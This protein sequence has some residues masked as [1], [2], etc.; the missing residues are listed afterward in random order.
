M[1]TNRRANIRRPDNTLS[2]LN[3]FANL[4]TVYPGVSIWLKRGNS[5]IVTVQG[6]EVGAEAEFRCSSAYEV[7]RGDVI[8]VFPDTDKKYRLEAVEEILSPTGRVLGY[9]GFLVRDSSLES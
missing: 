7:Q 5:M 4:E 3:S 1:K 8:E 2:G 9:S 6:E